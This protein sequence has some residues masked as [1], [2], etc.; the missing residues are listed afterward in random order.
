MESR[1]TELDPPRR[2]AFTWARSGDVSFELEPKGDDVLLT[3]I[4]RR[5]ADRHTMLKVGAG[6]HAHLDMLVARDD[7]HGAAAFW[8]RWKRLREDYDQR[9]PA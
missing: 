5:L 8:D 4:H 6:W 2:L 1:I 7:G 9:L 3:L